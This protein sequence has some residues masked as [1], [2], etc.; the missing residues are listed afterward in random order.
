[1]VNVGYCFWL[2]IDIGFLC[3]TMLRFSTSP[4]YDGVDN[5]LVQSWTRCAA[6]AGIKILQ[7]HYSRSRRSLYYIVSHKVAG[8]DPVSIW[9]WLNHRL[10]CT[11]AI[12]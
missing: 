6:K 10:L 7:P 12:S 2:M 4:R 3:S 1:V 9:L 5:G 11:I 8:E